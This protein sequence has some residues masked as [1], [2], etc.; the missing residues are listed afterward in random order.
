[1]DEGTRFHITPYLR[2]QMNEN[3]TRLAFSAKNHDEWVTWRQE[4]RQKLYD[5]L[6][7]WP[8]PVPLMPIVVETVECD[9]HIRELIVLSSHQNMEIPCILLRP[10]KIL[11]P[12]PAIVA[13]HGHGNG[14]SEV[15]GLSQSETR[16]GYGLE[17]VREGYVVITLDFFPFGARLETEHN[18]KNGYEYSCNSTLIRALLWGY[19]LLAL[20]LFD[21][22]RL[23]DYLET[24]KEVDSSRIGI[25]GC[26]YGGVTSMYA[27]I[28]DHRIKAAVLSCSLGE[29]RGHGIELD[30]LCGAQVVPGILQ[31][32][33]MG[34][35]VGLLA[36][37]PLLS[38]NTINDVCFPWAYTEPTLNRLRAVY[39]IA[40]VE[41]NLKILVHDDFHRYY[42]E[43]V[44]EFW[45]QYL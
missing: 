13:L 39:Q 20:N 14:K 27:A 33:E 35:V 44:A 31:W 1:M 45:R 17:M 12:T 2:R 26:S 23:I 22:F 18:A 3:P 29:Y 9:D 21:I 19:N 37:L 42:G 30:E 32:A 7:P 34:D 8:K 16:Q 5:L 10:K 24:R 4:L 40:G 28:L 36:P 6:G 25:M 11:H 41:N 38:E 15:V 43:G